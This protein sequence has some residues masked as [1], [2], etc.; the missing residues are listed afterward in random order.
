MLSKVG[1]MLCGGGGVGGCCV[2]THGAAIQEQ[3]W[4]QFRMLALQ[5]HRPEHI[6]NRAEQPLFESLFVFACVWAF[7]GALTEK[8]GVDCR[9]V[10]VHCYKCIRESQGACIFPPPLSRIFDKWWR[11]QWTS[12]RFPTKGTVFDY[13]LNF[14]TGRFA[15][16]GELVAP[17][18][19]PPDKVGPP[20]ICCIVFIYKFIDPHATAIF[21]DIQT[22]PH[23]CTKCT[24]NNSN[25]MVQG[26]DAVYVPT[27]ESASLTY[28][29]DAMVALHRPIMLVGGAGV[30]AIPIFDRPQF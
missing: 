12:V 5:L 1:G 10:L 21:K 2:C 22:R 8:D 29:L 30:G 11:G 14:K 17:L 20:F 13:Y 27:A 15:A 19:P 18:E 7:G 23:V 3:R 16:W 9:Y 4:S 6:S 24:K 28:F 25:N 26:M